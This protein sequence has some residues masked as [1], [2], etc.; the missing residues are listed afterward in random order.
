[1]FVHS[2]CHKLLFWS[3][4]HNQMILWFPFP[5]GYLHCYGQISLESW[6]CATPPFNYFRLGRGFKKS[7]IPAFYQWKPHVRLWLLLCKK[8]YRCKRLCFFLLSLVC[9]V[10]NLKEIAKYKGT[11]LKK[12]VCNWIVL[13]IHLYFFL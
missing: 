7:L 2:F 8:N 5:H 9:L 13:P 1:M 4:G 11:S 6:I 12:T 3:F 10:V